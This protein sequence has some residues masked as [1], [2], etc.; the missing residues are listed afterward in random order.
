MRPER[1]AVRLAEPMTRP[2]IP[3]TAATN[4]ERQAGWLRRAVALYGLLLIGP[5][6]PLW[7]P[8][9][10]FPQVPLAVHLLPGV[11]AQ[12]LATGMLLAGLAA[13]LV[14]AEGRVARVVCIVVAIG[15]AAAML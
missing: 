3:L 12:W 7:T 11:W 14:L 1:R 8:R 4:V 9:D 13:M 5:T 10:V 6:W 2:A 15:F